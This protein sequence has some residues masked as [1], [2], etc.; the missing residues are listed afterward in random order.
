MTSVVLESITV[1]YEL[2]GF[3]PT[4]LQH[5]LVDRITGGV[6]TGRQSN[7]T[8]IRALDNVSLRLQDGDRL[9]IVGGNGAGK[10]TLIKTI[11]GCIEPT[12][13]T[14]AVSGRIS[15]LLAVGAGM[16]GERTGLENIYH[17]GLHL[18]MLPEQ[19]HP[20]IDEI[21]DFAELGDFM[22]LPM[23]TYSDGMKLRL[24]FAVATCLKPEVLLLDEGIGA[25]DARFAQ[26]AQTRAMSL[27]ESSRIVVMAS[28][29]T[30]LL[31]QLC[32]KALLLNGGRVMHFGDI[33]TVLERYAAE[34]VSN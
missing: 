22:H 29:N 15:A 1:D 12:L 25:G 34:G 5:A 27:Y 8:R 7:Q 32:N 33:D 16:D 3:R 10:S 21:A 23:R 14:V 17:M 31:K 30:P 13:G 26:R 18:L 2:R 19:L 11:A 6:I 4:T 20:H 28:H 9:G 24:A